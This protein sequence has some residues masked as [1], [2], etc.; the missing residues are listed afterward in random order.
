MEITRAKFPNPQALDQRSWALV[1]VLVL[2][3]AMQIK[4]WWQPTPDAA[5]YLSIARH[6]SEGRL[7]L[8][9]TPHLKYA[10]GYPAI[11]APA[12]WV[13]PRPFLAISLIHFAL[14]VSVLGAV[15]VW[16]RRLTGPAALLLTAFVM[17]NVGL[18]AIYRRTLSEL[19]FM[20]GLMWSVHALHAAATSQTFRRTALW[21]AVSVLLLIFTC[22]VRQVG[23]FLLCGLTVTLGVRAIRREESWRRAVALTAAVSCPVVVALLGLIVWDQQMSAVAGQNAKSY[24]EYMVADGMTPAAQIV[25]GV[26]LRLSEFGRLLI[27]GMHK[28]YARPGEWFDVN[29]I[30]Y[31][32]LAAFLA[33]CWWKQTWRSN[34]I[35]L[36]TIPI[37]VAFFATW[38]FDQGT[39]YMVPILPVLVLCLWSALGR[40]QWRRQIVIGLVAV[41]AAVSIGNWARDL[42]LRK[43]NSVWPQLA[44]LAEP[45]RTEATPWGIGG[46]ET[47]LYAMALLEVD[48][49]VV[50]L[51]GDVD[52]DLPL[53]PWLITDIESP[54]PAGFTELRR[55]GT[56]RLLKQDSLAA[57][58]NNA[59]QRAADSTADKDRIAS[60]KQGVF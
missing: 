22:Y 58:T 55:A 34:D 18:W 29:T 6:M 32:V 19:A 41:H 48:R 31:A 3:L 28:A 16:F 20:A 36:W 8:F 2:L 5:C 13:S 7:A 47:D 45:L 50:K 42:Q 30:V 40:L 37:Y 57:H 26:R 44:E 17:V 4:W 46:V 15:L 23:V 56:L 49:C 9:D 24:H 14:A 1:V 21:T 10:P 59:R 25:E 60:R 33:G 39:R 43:T 52:A 51:S 54:A 11:I 12:F 53:P 35:L 38:P 27:P